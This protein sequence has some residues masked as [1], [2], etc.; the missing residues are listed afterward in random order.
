MG[1]GVV[2]GLTVG[3]SN[4][5]FG[6]TALALFGSLGTLWLSAMQMVVIPMTI[7]VLT[8]AIGRAGG[9]AAGR[10]GSVSVGWFVGMLAVAALATVAVTPLLL[11]TVPAGTMLGTAPTELLEAARGT[12]Q[13]SAPTLQDWLSHLVPTNLIRAAAD[14]DLFAAL[15]GTLLFA[16]ALRFLPVAQREPLLAL[17]DAVSAWCF[18]LSTLLLRALPVAVFAL[19]YTATV[20]SG[21]ESL[22]GLVHYVALLSALLVFATLGLYPVT[23]WLAKIPLRRLATALWPAQLLAFSTRSS[24]ACLPIMLDTARGPLALPPRAAEVTLPLAVASFKLNMGISAN[25]QLLFLLHV[26]GIDPAPGAV[27]VAVIALSLQSFATPGLPSGAVWT[28]TPIYLALGIPLEGI[29]LTNVVDTIPDLFKTVA[30]VTGD[31][32]IAAI[33][34][35]RTTV[36]AI[37]DITPSG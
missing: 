19:T 23:A 31:L 22:R 9:G 33:V 25:F 15:V 14:G 29:V 36:P 13:G 28:T 37:A 16:V 35:R 34:A 18:A 10:V 7:A 17:A 27:V 8:V 1:L 11:S 2:L 12:A 30:N 26:Y 3:R 4:D 5:S 24:V 6:R 32:S 20:Q 21:S